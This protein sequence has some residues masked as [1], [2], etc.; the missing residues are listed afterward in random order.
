VFMVVLVIDL[1]HILKLNSNGSHQRP[2]NSM[3][4]YMGVGSEHA[5]LEP[6]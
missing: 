3:A 5:R 6:K 4:I 2:H 1:I